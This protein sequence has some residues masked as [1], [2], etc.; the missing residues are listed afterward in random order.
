MKRLIL[1]CI[2]LIPSFLF[3]QEV[4]YKLKF[5]EDGHA[6][7]AR[8]TIEEGAV[9]EV[10]R[11]T[12]VMAPGSDIPPELP[13][14]IKDAINAMWTPEVIQAQLD[15]RRERGDF[16]AWKEDW[17]E[18]NT[19]E[20]VATLEEALETYQTE[21]KIIVDHKTEYRFDSETGQV[22]EVQEPLYGSELV[23]RTRLKDGYRI[24]EKTGKVM[25]EVKP[26]KAE[27]EAALDAELADGK[28]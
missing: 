28:I 26:S 24:D 21:K 10:F 14:R 13:Q 3:A 11:F 15:K 18:A 27:V 5:N 19:T 7:V 4:K 20:T 25:K 8:I 23:E 22:K 12:G 1:L 2:L 6:S 16:D 17:I 9:Q